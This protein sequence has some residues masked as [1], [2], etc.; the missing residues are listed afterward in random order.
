[1]RKK[2]YD[3]SIAN[4]VIVLLAYA[5]M[6]L[7]LI[8]MIFTAEKTNWFMIIITIL[9]VISLLLVIWYYVILAPVLTE[10]GIKH[11]NK[12][13]D[14]KDIKWKVEYNSRFRY[15]EIIIYNKY[16]NFDKLDKKE[17][18]KKAIIIQCYPQ[19]LKTIEEYL[20]K[21]NKKKRL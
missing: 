19:H 1:M 17:R 18:K 3:F 13:I 14:R 9:L 4:A 11:G 15:D 7:F 10:K 12:T 16:V 5:F 8:Y 6:I 2:L 21:N 20:S